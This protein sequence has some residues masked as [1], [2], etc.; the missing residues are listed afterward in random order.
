M[1]QPAGN[2]PGEG[3]ISYPR[4]RKFEFFEFTERPGTTKPEC[5]TI[6]A[7]QVEPGLPPGGAV[8]LPARAQGGPHAPVTLS[9]NLVK[10]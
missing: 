9:C 8:A 4:I 1:V 6:V 3:F 7:S 10:L 2:G 5:G